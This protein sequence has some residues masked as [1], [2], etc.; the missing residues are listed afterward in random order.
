[1]GS[2]SIGLDGALESR[3]YLPSDTKETKLKKDLLILTCGL[4][5]I[6]VVGWLGI[7]WSMGIQ[8]ST[9][10]PLGYQVISV[11]S[12]A[13]FLITRNF[14]FFRII[15]LSLFLFAPFI[16]QWSIGNYVTSS[17]VALWAF[18]S[19]LGA[20]FLY[21]YRESIPWFTA[22][23]ILNALSGFFDYYLM[24]GIQSGVP[25]KTIAVFFSLNFVVV[26]TIIFLLVRFFV[27]E[28][29]NIKKHLDE[30]HSLLLLEQQ[31]S[32]RLLLNM[33]PVHITKRL[34][35]N[36][37]TIADGHADIT[38]AFADIINFT[39]LTEEMSP[40]QMVVLLNG[41]FSSFDSL[42]EKYDLE[43]IKTIGDAYMAAGGLV[44]VHS[45]YVS[46]MADM[47]LE[48]IELIT[49][50]P[51]FR[52]YNLGIHIGI[53][54]GPLVGGVIGTKRLVYDLWGDTVNV[55]SRLSTYSVSGKIQVD[56]TTYNRLR[57]RYQFDG[58]HKITVKGKGEL[59]M[60]WLEGAPQAAK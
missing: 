17:G 18:L 49:V 15:Q 37:A 34:K 44:N 55:A 14:N 23:I 45:D 46:A 43:K 2:K 30:E 47:T 16:M 50:K 11:T 32:E 52:K 33:L 48:M 41:V 53:S 10:V 27:Q 58:P 3:V 21:G 22:Y 26:S 57:N 9:T 5:N 6:G 56:T 25:L 60:Y 28:Q 7:Y 20:M 4:M 59:T 19:P 13:I 36:S 51:E 38:V 31:K 12:L 8:F 42:V 1:M 54:T 35:Q 39:R 24:T 40:Q 29:E